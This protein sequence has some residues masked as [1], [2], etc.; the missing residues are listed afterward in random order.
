MEICLLLWYGKKDNL[1]NIIRNKEKLGI[2][3]KDTYK[4]ICK[5]EY[6]FKKII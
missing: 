3:N 6:K 2:F 1:W 5:I 4:E